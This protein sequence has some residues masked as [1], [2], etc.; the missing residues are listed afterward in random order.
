MRPPLSILL[1][2]FLLFS[3]I[4]NAQEVEIPSKQ[5][6]TKEEF[7]SSEK[8]VIAV[9]KW[10]AETQI[11]TQTEQRTKANAWVIAWLINSP[12]VSITINSA[13]IK[14]FEKNAQ[15]NAVWMANYARYVLENNYSKDEVK[16]HV[17]A[18]KAV[19]AC[20]NLGGDIKKDK[21]LSKMMDA[22]KDGK[23]EDW[24]KE[25]LNSK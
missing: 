17:F 18:L 15:L 16:A 3:A 12:T 8:D 2:I 9:A 4:S 21:A 7:V 14:L 1:G 22:D 11:G 5:P 20:Y 10:L 24:V 13:F 19:I 6:S 25:A 23:L